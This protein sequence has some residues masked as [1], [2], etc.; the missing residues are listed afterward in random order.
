MEII[1]LIKNCNKTFSNSVQMKVSQEACKQMQRAGI[2]IVSSQRVRK[3]MKTHAVIPST[4]CSWGRDQ[5]MRNSPSSVL[6]F[7]HLVIS[8]YS[9]IYGLTRHGGISNVASPKWDF[10]S[11]CHNL[12]LLF[13]IWDIKNMA[14]MFEF[15]ISLALLSYKIGFAWLNMSNA[16]WSTWEYLK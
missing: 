6:Y 3:T 5:V 2:K 15:Q 13:T 7:N 1:I 16:I 4:G 10:L 14:S 11:F 9:S 12:I 8:I